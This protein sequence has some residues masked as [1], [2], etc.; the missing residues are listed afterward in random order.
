MTPTFGQG[1]YGNPVTNK[2]MR[3]T[4]EVDKIYVGEA[5][6]YTKQ[7]SGGGG[8]GGSS[9]YS[10]SLVSDDSGG[11][12]SYKAVIQLTTLPSGATGYKVEMTGTEDNSDSYGNPQAYTGVV[13]YIP[14]PVDNTTY[15][16]NQGSPSTTGPQ[17]TNNT[18]KYID[19][20]KRIE[21]R[22]DSDNGMSNG[23]VT[24]T[25]I[26]ASNNTVGSASNTITGIEITEVP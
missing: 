8:G 23:T 10:I 9:S 2:I 21:I 15:Q 14:N 22:Q 20:T 24:V 26:D 19:S 7:S 18:V 11:G 12:Y 13:V 16:A 5:L 1:G 17:N 3:G 6:A 4:D 25:P